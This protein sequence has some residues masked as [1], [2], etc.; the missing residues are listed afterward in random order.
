MSL[1]K[2]LLSIRNNDG[3]TPLALATTKNSRFFR[4]MMNFEK[5]YKIPQN[6]LGSIAWVTYDVT[7]IASFARGVYNKFSVLHILAHNSQHLS[8]HASI[9]DVDDDFMEMEPVRTLL[10]RK[11]DVYRWIYILWFVVHLAYMVLL[12]SVT[13]EEINTS[14]V[15][16]VMTPTAPAYLALYPYLVPGSL[17]NLTA[18]MRPL[19]SP[20]EPRT[21]FAI[22]TILPVIYLVLELL[23]LFGSAPYRINFMTGQSYPRRLVKT[24]QSEWTITGNGPYRMVSVGFS[25]F[26]ICWFVLYTQRHDYQDMGLAMSMLLGWIF[27]LFFTRGCRVTCRFSIMIQ[28]MFFRDLIYFLT[29]YGIVLIGFSFA[30]KVMIGFSSISK[31]FYGMMSVVTDLDQKQTNHGSRHPTFARVL[32][33]FYAIIAVI[34]LMNMLIAMMNTSYE[35]VRVTRCNLWRQ[36]Q[37]SILLMMERRFFWLKWICRKSE[38]DIWRKMDARSAEERCFIDVT[39]LHMPGG[40]HKSSPV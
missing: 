1:F 7:D 36:Q 35:T 33:I 4:H 8:R 32:L 25:V 38:R 29:V 37:L 18:A 12:T 14:S 19:P 6:R 28:K 26:T 13:A 11:W 20:Q 21:G 23:D 34:L 24:V 16:L 17:L 31:V 15:P 27:V 40:G 9:E 2:E 5:I 30:M 10:T 39:M 3:Y 22:F